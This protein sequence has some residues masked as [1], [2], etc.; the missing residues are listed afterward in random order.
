MLEGEINFGKN[1]YS[2]DFKYKV[3]NKTLEIDTPTLYNIKF[4]SKKRM[5]VDNL[6]QVRFI[7][8]AI[9]RTIKFRQNYR[10]CLQ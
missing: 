6:Q 9:L 3:F 10:F 5:I 4:A 8:I 2:P 1:T 7:S